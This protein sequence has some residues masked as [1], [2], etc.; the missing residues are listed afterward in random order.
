MSRAHGCAGATTYRIAVGPQADSSRLP[1]TQ[2]PWETTEETS[3]DDDVPQDAAS[4]AAADRKSD[5][6]A[7]KGQQ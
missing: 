3:Q 1:S 7:E 5:E 6:E 4:D 2:A